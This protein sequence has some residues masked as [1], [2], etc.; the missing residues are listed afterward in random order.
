MKKSPISWPASAGR[1]ALRP[2]MRAPSLREISTQQRTSLSTAVQ[3]YRLLEDRGILEVRPQSGYYV[4]KAP[5]ALPVPTTTRHSIRPA[6]VELSGLM[7]DLLEHAS[8]DTLVPLGCAI[9]NQR[10]LSS[11]KLDLVLARTARVKGGQSN[12]YS[13]PRGEMSLRLEIARRALRYG[14]ALSPD[15]I[16]ITCG[17]TEALALALDAVTEPG[18]TVAIESPTYFGLLQVLRAKR[19]KVVELPTD[20]VTGVDV[21]AL[22]DIVASG[23]VR[24]CVLASSF[25]NPLGCTMPEDNKR[26]VLRLL[27]KHGVPLIEDDVYG[28]VHFG[29]ERPLPFSAL[30]THD[31]VIYCGSFSKTL[32]P[33]Y[34]I[35]W[36]ATGRHMARVL[37]T[38]F[39]T[40]LATPVLTQVALATFLSNGDY[41]RH[42]RR[43]RREFADTLEPH[44]AGDRAGVSAGHEG[45]AARRKLCAV[46]R[47]ARAGRHAP[48]VCAGARKR[49]LLRARRR[50][51]G[52]RQIRPLPAA[53]RRP[54]LGRP[55]REGPAH[56]RR[57]GAQGARGA[58]SKFVTPGLDNGFKAGVRCRHREN[59]LPFCKVRRCPVQALV[60]HNGALRGH[61][62][63]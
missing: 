12:T 23:K 53:E 49:H 34:R 47:A 4:A 40:S 1:G 62:F 50:V 56:A 57:H 63:A 60:T 24:A 5:P 20:A 39:A 32:A 28:D 22:G 26:A 61:H 45:V 6:K 30:D 33:G 27:A 11:S 7:L 29:E 16:A 37:E 43:I 35:G 13:P 19:L 31:N 10:L 9:P 54:R 18:D 21:D 42:L 59:S 46:G 58:H 55:D 41:D 48:A 25:S 2:G 14:Q 38:K 15:D 8:D 52:Q 51:L 17:C 36:I 3:A 44:D